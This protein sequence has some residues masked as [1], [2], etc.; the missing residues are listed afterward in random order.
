MRNAAVPFVAA[1]VAEEGLLQ[2]LLPIFVE[3]V[4]RVLTVN[5]HSIIAVSHAQQ[6][7]NAVP[8]LA[9]AKLIG[10]IELIGGFVNT[11]SAAVLREV[12]HKG[13][14]NAAAVALR[15]V[16]RLRLQLR[17]LI[18]GELV[19]EVEDV[20]HIGVRRLLC[21]RLGA[22]TGDCLGVFACN[23]RR[24]VCMDI[25][26]HALRHRV[27]RLRERR[28]AHRHIFAVPRALDHIGRY[29]VA[30]NV[31]QF[32]CAAPRFIEKGIYAPVV[33]RERVRAVRR[34]AQQQRQRNTVFRFTAAVAGIFID[35]G[36]NIFD[37]RVLGHI[38]LREG[39]HTQIDA[40]LLREL[41]EHLLSL[42]GQLD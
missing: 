1:E 34:A 37:A 41:R 9:H 17:P 27:H 10:V 20:V 25:I 11:V 32:L 42:I 31:G 40:K 29:R 35:I 13:S 19:A 6:D 3:C 16:R 2:L 5:K 18:E 33:L 7:D 15:N 28:S 39:V 12:I 38:L 14:V 8:P 26:L 24:S 22:F 30:D 36:R 21:L 23:V 4:L